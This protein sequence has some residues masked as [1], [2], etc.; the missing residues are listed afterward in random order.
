MIFDM[1]RRTSGGT[2]NYGIFK[3]QYGTI[4][5]ATNVSKLTITVDANLGTEVW[6]TGYIP[7]T[8]WSNYEGDANY[9]NKI[10]GWQY[11][12]A[13]NYFASNM[14]AANTT[15]A[16]LSSN[17]NGHTYKSG[18]SSFSGNTYT[19]GNLSGY[20]FIGGETYHYLIVGV[21]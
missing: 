12:G 18:G 14:S 16:F 15:F 21:T 6:A 11:N 1:T 17:A 2:P 8:R 5:P 4:T 7:N 13:K 19:V 20:Q 10:A 9:D 3:V